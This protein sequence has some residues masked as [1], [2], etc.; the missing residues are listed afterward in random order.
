MASARDLWLCGQGSGISCWQLPVSTWQHGAALNSENVL[1]QSMQKDSAAD[2]HAFSC[3]QQ[4]RY[5][6][7]VTCCA[8]LRYLLQVDVSCEAVSLQLPTTA[9][10]ASASLTPAAPAEQLVME[11]GRCMLGGRFNITWVCQ[12]S[13]APLTPSGSAPSASVGNGPV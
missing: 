8:I 2:L 1:Q 6:I 10:T 5:K 13:L 9:P 3:A 4:A 12:A 7:F 11:A